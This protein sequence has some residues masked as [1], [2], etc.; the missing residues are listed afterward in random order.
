[1]TSAARKKS[2]AAFMLYVNMHV[3]DANFDI[4]FPA[5]LRGE[6]LCY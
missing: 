6:I 4:V 1:M 2:S 3:S 5:L